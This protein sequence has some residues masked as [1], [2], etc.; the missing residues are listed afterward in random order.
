M[1]STLNVLC[2]RTAQQNQCTRLKVTQHDKAIRHHS[3]RGQA[4]YIKPID[5]YI[6]CLMERRYA[7]KQRCG[8]CHVL[9]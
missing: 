7:Y 8:R 4:H 1:L 2:F 6:S 3:A 5:V 9:I